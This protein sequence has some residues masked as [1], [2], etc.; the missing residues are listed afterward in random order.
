MEAPAIAMPPPEVAEKKSSMGLILGGVGAVVVLG[1]VLAVWA[2][3]KTSDT[4][5][6]QTG[7]GQTE[8]PSTPGGASGGGT[9]SGGTSPIVPTPTPPVD[10]W[11]TP[12]GKR[13]DSLLKEARRLSGKADY[14][15]ANRKLDEAEKLGP[16]GVV[17]EALR[18]ERLS[19]KKASEDS[20]YREAVRRDNDLLNQVATLRQTET[21]DSLNRALGLVN[22]GISNN[23]PRVEDF[24]RAKPEIESRISFVRGEGM[25]RAILSEGQRLLR[26]EKFAEARAK[27]R[28]LA[29][30][31]GDASALLSGIGGDEIKKK[32]QLDSM[33]DRASRQNNAGA[34][35]PLIAEYRKFVYEGGPYANDGREMAESRI[36]GEIS[37]IR[38]PVPP[39]K[40]ETP[41]KQP[42]GPAVVTCKANFR[43]F[44][45]G[46]DKYTG[47]LAAGRLISDNYIDGGL[48]LT[49][50]TV[51]PD[52]LQQACGKNVRI[53]FDVNESGK[54]TG[55]TVMMGDAALGK[56]L[57]DVAQ[58]SWQFSP[59][60]VSNVPVKTNTTY[61][62]NFQ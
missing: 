17:A 2:P 22:S 62:I 37:R 45:S 51:P 56:Q 35:E 9:P 23:G 27:A 46:P 10:P 4:G 16:E 5:G 54:V 6:P 11:T 49:A 34:L 52:I 55:G 47:P 12:D 48:K 3:W 58:K 41:A 30:A 14:T 44:A 7:G 26:D 39:T 32:N 1:I 31:G 15:G 18:T 57:L 43:S 20:S 8:G 53:R 33:F 36:P 19:I 25:R 60:K 40:V 59:P 24:R 21:E 13:I 29:A 42:T 61:Q 28:E 50:S 38:T